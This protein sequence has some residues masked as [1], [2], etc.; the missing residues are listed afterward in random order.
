MKGEMPNAKPIGSE[1]IQEK[2][3]TPNST[4]EGANTGFRPNLSAAIPKKG[5][6]II[7]GIVK[8]II[9]R[10]I[11]PGGTPSSRPILGN[12]GV[13]LATPM[14]AMRVVPKMMSRLADKGRGSSFLPSEDISFGFIL[15]ASTPNHE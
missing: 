6:R 10:L 2:P 15:A 3:A 5:V 9:T 4:K 13:M 7:P 14:T 11:I 8:M 12:A 1:N